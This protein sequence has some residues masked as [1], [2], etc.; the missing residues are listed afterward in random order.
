MPGLVRATLSFM[1]LLVLYQPNSERARVT[2]EYLREFKRRHPDREVTLV[3]VDGVEGTALARLYDVVHYPTF[4]VVR[5][6]KGLV[7]AWS[8]EQFPLMDDVYGYLN[9]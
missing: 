6:D 9:S 8:D 4:L 3:D 1:E 5:G 2:E 7:N